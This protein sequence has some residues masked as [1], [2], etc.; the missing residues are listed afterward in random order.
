M[1]SSRL[2]HS[3][4]LPGRTCTFHSRRHSSTSGQ[5]SPYT[6]ASSGA[7]SSV[8]RSGYS[9][10]GE[11][12]FAGS[13]CCSDLASWPGLSLD[14]T[15]TTGLRSGSGASCT[16]GALC[17]AAR[18]GGPP[19]TTSPSTGASL[20]AWLDSSRS[21]RRSRRLN[22]SACSSRSAFTSAVTAS[23]RTRDSRSS[24]AV[25]SC[26]RG[27]ALSLRSSA[28]RTSLDGVPRFRLAASV[29]GS[30]ASASAV[31][32]RPR[33]CTSSRSSAISRWSCGSAAFPFVATSIQPALP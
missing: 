20:R 12:F 25:S 33:S 9:L 4:P 13:G 30:T 15:S 18:G 5:A 21:S 16:P 22:A 28:A 2:S 19:T 6:S 17:R 32:A 10:G 7:G 29:R 8:T 31:R 24:K 26:R 1:R 14:G 3:S 11:Y 27:P 23:R